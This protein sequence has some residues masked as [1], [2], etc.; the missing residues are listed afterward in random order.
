MTYKD[1]LVY[2][3]M[4]GNMWVQNEYTGEA[5]KSAISALGYRIAKPPVKRFDDDNNHIYVC[6]ICTIQSVTPD[7]DYCPHCGQNL[8]WSDT[9]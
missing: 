6:Q 5:E 8:N 3:S 7:F 9:E 1:A 4:R 2:F